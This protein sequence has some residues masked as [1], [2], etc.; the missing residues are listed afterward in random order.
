MLA[1]GF[2]MDHDNH[3]EMGQIGIYI[4]A[5]CIMLVHRAGK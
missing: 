1:L 4:N 3:I 5:S 2:D